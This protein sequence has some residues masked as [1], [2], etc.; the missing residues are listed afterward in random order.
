MPKDYYK[1]LNIGKNATKDE[2]KRAYRRLA[3][4]YHPDKNGGDDQKFKEINEAYQVLSND[5]KRQQ[6]DQFGTTFDQGG[7]SGFGGQNVDWENIFSTFGQNHGGQQG[8]YGTRINLEDLFSD[9][10]SDFFTGAG[11]STRR[12]RGKNVV[13]D[14]KINLEDILKG[15]EKEIKLDDTNFRFRIKVDISKKESK[16]IKKI[17]KKAKKENR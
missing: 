17:L 15:V 1:I 6:Y 12:T 10:F 13:V 2:I 11:F 16:E 14:M 9:I 4:Q 3:H 8:F 7:F 5:A